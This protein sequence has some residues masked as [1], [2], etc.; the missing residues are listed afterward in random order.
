MTI[1][2]TSIATGTGTGSLVSVYTAPAGVTAVVQAATFSNATAGALALTVSANDGAADRNI[3]DAKSIT[4]HANYQ[5][6]GMQGLTLKPGNIL[7]I[8][9]AAGID[10][11]VSG[12]LVV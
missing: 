7:K 12:I 4:G 3:E 6:P 11:W 5:P 10:Y 2:A 9:A 8:N 1:T